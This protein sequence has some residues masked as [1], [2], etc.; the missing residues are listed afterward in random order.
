[1][2]QFYQYPGGVVSVGNSP[3][4]TSPM[5]ARQQLFNGFTRSSIY[6]PGSPSASRRSPSVARFYSAGSGPSTLHLA[7]P[8]AASDVRALQSINEQAR[9]IIEQADSLSDSI[10]P[11]DGQPIIQGDSI[12]TKYGNAPLPR[13]NILDTQFG[14]QLVELSDALARV[15]N[16]PNNDVQAL[17][18]V[19]ELS[20]D[21]QLNYL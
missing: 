10:F 20:R 15:M 13:G 12:R 18:K 16:S 21:M 4:M 9:P 2:P 3:M 11:N 1:M 7:A 6:T 8:S 19:L 14:A 5:M 17:N